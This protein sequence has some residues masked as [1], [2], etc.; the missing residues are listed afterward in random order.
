MAREFSLFDGVL[1]VFEA[2]GQNTE[3][4]R[5]VASAIQNAI[6]AYR[7]IYDE[8]RSYNPGITGSF[9]LFF[10]FFPKRVERIESSKEPE[11]VPST[12]GVS[13]FAVCPP[14]SSAEDISAPIPS[15]SP[16][17]SRYLFLPVHWMPVPGCQLLYCTTGLCKVLYCQKHFFYFLFLLLCVICG[18][19]IVNL[20]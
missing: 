7:V 2:Q 20:L 1:L 9:S 11:A 12:S 4:Y 3:Q 19:S 18:K 16:S 6:Q 17:S 14:S 15:V 8:K 5:K 10:F 13:E